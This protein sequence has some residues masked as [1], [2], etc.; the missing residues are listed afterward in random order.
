LACQN[1]SEWDGN[2]DICAI[3]ISKEEY[4]FTIKVRS[5]TH[6]VPQLPCCVDFA[7]T[8]IDSTE[9]EE[10]TGKERYQDFIRTYPTLVQRLPLKLIASF[11]GVTPEYLSEIRKKLVKK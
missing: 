4:N 8:L 2:G 11:I 7:K 3:V 1:E 5:L 6:E 10:L 9:D